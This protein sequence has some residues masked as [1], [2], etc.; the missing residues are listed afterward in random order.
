MVYVGL[1]TDIS[2]FIRQGAVVR[3]VMDCTL[4]WKAVG[5]KIESRY[6]LPIQVE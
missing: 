6:P 1:L 5:S 4:A 2:A 3:R